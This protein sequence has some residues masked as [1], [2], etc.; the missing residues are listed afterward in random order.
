MTDK[1]TSSDNRAVATSN[2][3]INTTIKAIKS[4]TTKVR[5]LIQTGIVQCIEHG[6]TFGDVTGAARLVDAIPQEMR[7]A[8]VVKH[9]SDYS[10]IRIVTQGRGK[11]MKASLRKQDDQ[12][13]NDW[14][15]EGV[16]ANP[17]YERDAIARADQR[18]LAPFDVD[19]A[20]K[21]V[22]DLAHLFERK[23]SANNTIVVGEDG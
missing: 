7:R 8:E 12:G 17:W 4:A 22:I 2:A 9:F 13:Y 19:N 10:P 3:A 20:E 15:V 18:D 6:K 11:P 21:R 14:N 5:A 1:N 16:K 23:S